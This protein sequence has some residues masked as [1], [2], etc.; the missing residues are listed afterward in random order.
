MEW[1][2]IMTSSIASSRQGNFCRNSHRRFKPRYCSK[3]APLWQQPLEELYCC[4]FENPDPCSNPQKCSTALASCSKPITI[5]RT[6]VMHEQMHN[7]ATVPLKPV[8]FKDP[9]RRTLCCF[10]YRMKSSQQQSTGPSCDA[11]FKL[12]TLQESTGQNLWHGSKA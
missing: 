10:S 8:S 4:I 5:H 3:T 1:R 2:Y 9:Q 11:T 7:T 6:K 12:P